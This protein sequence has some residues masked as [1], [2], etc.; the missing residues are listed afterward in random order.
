MF[1]VFVISLCMFVVLYVVVCM[2]ALL[3]RKSSLSNCLEV[4]NNQSINQCVID[5]W[6]MRVGPKLFYGMPGAI[7]SFNVVH[8]DS[9]VIIVLL[10][11]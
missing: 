8:V 7:L 11:K 1:I 2:Y 9:V 5:Y 6:G 10:K 3:A 4:L